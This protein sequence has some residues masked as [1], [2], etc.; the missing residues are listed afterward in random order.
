MFLPVKTK[1]FKSEMA[2]SSLR[3]LCTVE[4]HGCTFCPDANSIAASPKAFPTH[5][6]EMGGLTKRMRS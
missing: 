4:M 6:V 3:P 5:R 2:A 1:A